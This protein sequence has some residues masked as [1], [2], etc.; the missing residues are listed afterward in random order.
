MS[1]HLID[2]A[3]HQDEPGRFA[4]SVAFARAEGE[5]GLHPSVKSLTRRY[6]STPDDSTRL[7]EFLRIVRGRL[8]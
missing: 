7:R 4:R 3:A 6:L 5:A 8:A 1:R 2:T